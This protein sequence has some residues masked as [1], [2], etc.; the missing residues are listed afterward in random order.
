MNARAPLSAVAVALALAL[1]LVGCSLTRPPLER[2]TYALGA[3]RAGAPAAQPK[4]I[5]VRVRPFRAAAPYDGREFLYRKADGQLITDFYNAFPAGPGELITSATAQ[6]LRS[7]GLF[8][9]VLEPGITADAP[10]ALEGSVL[11]IYADLANPQRPAAV[12]EVQVYLVRSTPAGRELAL[13]G[14]FA[15]RVDVAD[16]SPQ[17]LARGYNEAL[18]RVLARLERELAVIDVRG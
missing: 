9:A 5:A 12:L 8:A 13:D 7:A 4:P 11:A 14:R 2:S 16:S 17:S 1:A 15:E 6:W 18:A 3:T 10:Y